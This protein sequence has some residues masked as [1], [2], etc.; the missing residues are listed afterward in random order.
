MPYQLSEGPSPDGAGW[1]VSFATGTSPASVSV[2]AMCL[3]P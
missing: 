3:A 2:S 1:T